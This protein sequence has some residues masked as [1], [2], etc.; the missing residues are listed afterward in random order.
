MNIGGRDK[1]KA[2]AYQRAYYLAHRAEI[3]SRSSAYNSENSARRSE[4]RRANYAAS[5]AVRAKNAAYYQQNKER[6]SRAV[7]NRIHSDPNRKLLS[8]L[9][10]R[11]SKALRRRTNK[12]VSTTTE[13]LGCTIS[14]LRLHLESKFQPGMAWN[15]YGAWHVDHIKPC[16]SF[17]FSKPESQRV[18][19]HFSNL[20]PLWA[21]D[22]IAKG[23]T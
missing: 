6:I 20:Q 23:A 11:I 4:R 14:D 13:L 12:K 10:K 22:N 17:D 15:N 21:A 1:E 9:R 2:R 8:L 19:F 18:C 7:L 3:I 5:S 16:A